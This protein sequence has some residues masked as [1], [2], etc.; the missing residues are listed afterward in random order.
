MYDDFDAPSSM[1]ADSIANYNDV[2][3]AIH[4]SARVSIGVRCV[5]L[6]AKGYSYE[7]IADIDGIKLGTVKSRIVAGRAVIREALEGYPF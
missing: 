6:Y 7:E 1:R 4:R 3:E 5:I 2:L